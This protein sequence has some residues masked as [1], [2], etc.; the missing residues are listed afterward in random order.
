[1][2]S[3]TLRATRKKR[4]MTQ[5]ELSAKSGVRQTAISKLELGQIGSPEWLTVARLAAALRVRPESLFPV[6]Q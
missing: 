4:G 6:S 3:N 2:T 5:V 1:M